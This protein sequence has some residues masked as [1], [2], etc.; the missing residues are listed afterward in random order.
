MSATT[1]FQ[2]PG[3]G[4]WILRKDGCPP[5][6]LVASSTED[7]MAIAAGEL[8]EGDE[9]SDVL[10]RCGECSSLIGYESEYDGVCAECGAEIPVATC[11]CGLAYTR[12]EWAALEALRPLMSDGA[13][14]WLELRNC[15]C[16]STICRQVTPAKEDTK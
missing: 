3:H 1:R 11:A 2:G 6:P 9:T 13:G 10:A 16:R 14:G 7:M 12:D 5:A 8:V 4:A 15:S